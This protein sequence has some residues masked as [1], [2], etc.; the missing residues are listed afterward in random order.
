MTQ[1]FVYTVRVDAASLAEA[2]V[3]MNERLGPDEDYGFEYS[4]EWE[5]D[6]W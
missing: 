2:D 4:V 5:S 1:T 3:V 6:E